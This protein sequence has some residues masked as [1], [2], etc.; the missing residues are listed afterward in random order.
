MTANYV[1][2]VGD[3]KYKTEINTSAE[4]KM[5]APTHRASGVSAVGNF[6]ISSRV[7]LVDF[8]AGKR[9]E[10]AKEEDR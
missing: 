3:W 6:H 4:R 1:T 7:L 2:M 9:N 8:S 10:N 5:Q